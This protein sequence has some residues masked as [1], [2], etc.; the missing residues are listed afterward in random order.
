MAQARRPVSLGRVPPQDSLAERALLGA[1]LMP[2]ANKE[3]IPAVIEILGSGEAF[4][5]DAHRRIYVAIAELFGQNEPVDLVTVTKQLEL[6]GDLEKVGGVAELDTIWD[7]SPSAANAKTYAA[8]I[9]ESYKRRSVINIAFRGFHDGFDD[10]IGSPQLIGSIEQSLIELQEKYEHGKVITAKVAVRNALKHLT[11][12]RDR[13]DDILGL[14]TGFRDLDRILSGLQDADMIVIAG[15]P[16]MGKSMLAQNIAQNIARQNNPVLFFSC[17]TSS[18][19]L[20]MRMLARESA[21]PL[22]K[23]RAARMQ[24]YEWPNFAQVSGVVSEMP[25][26]LDDTPGISEVELT[27]KA[28]RLHMQHSLKLIV[29][30]YLQLMRPAQR[31]ENRQQ[32]VS[33]IS[34]ALKRL[35]KDL[36]IPVIAVSQL[37]RNPESRPDKRPKLADL[38]ESGEVEQDAD[39]VIL[40]FRQSYYDEEAENDNTDLIIAKQ[41]N[42]PTGTVHLFTD[43]ER[44][45]FANLSPLTEAD[46]E[47]V[48]YYE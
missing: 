45:K 6:M 16:A 12:M 8:I 42:G 37:N 48:Q 33:A 19:Q 11:S 31:Y 39:V 40:M 4:Y 41:R 27:A 17:E 3:A 47:E 46:A 25:I 26:F 23:I 9:L 20:I 30:D 43:S 10:T 21:I 1:M 5:K 44:M 13:G 18:Q 28:R 35:A 38:R 2:E 36:N 29:V 32:E 14:K 22:Y 24:E 34:M 15:R 7:S